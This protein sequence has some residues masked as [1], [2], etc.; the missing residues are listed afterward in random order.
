MLV[1][2]GV[3][4]E[5]KVHPDTLL[6]KPADEILRYADKQNVGLIAMTSSGSSIPGPWL[7]GNIVAKVVRATIKPL[8]LVRAPASESAIKEKRLIKRILVP[9]DGSKVGESAIPYA[10]DLGQALGSEI[11]IVQVLP[12]IETKAYMEG[13]SYTKPIAT[14][15][16]GKERKASALT[17]LDDA[18]KPLKEIGIRTS[19]IALIGSPADRITD[20]AKDNAIDL[21]AMST[22]GRTGIGRWVFGSVTDKVLHSGDAGVLVIRAP[23]A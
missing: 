20:Y 11:I 23:K 15:E 21:I 9:L 2:L 8:L 16:L 13:Y 17:Y 7:L 5:V 14:E 4:E 3:K 19:S 18:G 22:H 10:R 12:P 6:G 1:D